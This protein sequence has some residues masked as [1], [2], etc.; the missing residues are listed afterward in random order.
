MWWEREEKEGA[1]ASL[2][3]VFAGGRSSVKINSFMLPNSSPET[4]EG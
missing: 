1:E 2:L 3:P 4:T